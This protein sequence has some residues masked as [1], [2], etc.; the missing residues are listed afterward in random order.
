MAGKIPRASEEA[1]ALEEGAMT[2][3]ASVHLDAVMAPSKRAAGTK[4]R[5]LLR[6]TEER[7]RE[8]EEEGN[9][10]HDF[11]EIDVNRR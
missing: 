7:E 4:V 9:L 3:G 8:E 11:V 6:R 1:L 2:A 10:V 5:L